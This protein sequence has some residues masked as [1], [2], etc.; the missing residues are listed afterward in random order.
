[1]DPLTF[2]LPPRS[3]VVFSADPSSSSF[4]HLSTHVS[5]SNAG[6]GV[7]PAPAPVSNFASRTFSS[8]TSA[9]PRLESL[10][11]GGLSRD[12]IA[13]YFNP[14][15]ANFHFGEGHPMKPP[16]LALTYHL[17]LG[18]GLHR[19]MEV[20][21][22]R[23]ATDEEI[24]TFHSE[25]YI[26]FLKRVN[27]DNAAD[28]AKFM[29]RFNLGVDDCPVFEGMYDFCQLYSGGSLE[30]ARK[31][32]AGTADIAIN[33]SGG[34]HHAKKFEASG[35]CYVNDIVLAILELM[36]YFPRV[37]YIDIDVH[38][39]D[40]VQEAFLACPRVMTVSFHKYDGAFFPG[41]GSIEE[42]GVKAGK[43]YSINVPLQE[44]IDDAQYLYIF[45]HTISLVM[46]TYQPS[47]VVLQ[48]GADSLASDRLGC[49][50]L[51]IRGHGE[52]VK[53]VKS[54]RIPMLV[55]GGGGYTIRNVARAWTYECSILTNTVVPDELPR[56]DYHEHFA[57]DYSLHP[58][59]VDPN[60]HDAN[61]RQSLDA[62]K[63][64]IAEYLRYIASAPSV[65]M[66]EV[67]PGIAAFMDEGKWKDEQDDKWL[68]RRFGGLASGSRNEWS[69]PENE[70]EFYEG[71]ADQGGDDS[72]ELNIG[73]D[74]S[75]PNHDNVDNLHVKAGADWAAKRAGSPERPLKRP[76]EGMGA[77]DGRMLKVVVTERQ[78]A[79]RSVVGAGQ[80]GY[81]VAD[82]AEVKFEPGLAKLGD[83]EP[84]CSNETEFK[85]EGDVR[86]IVGEVADAVSLQGV[87]SAGQLEHG[88]C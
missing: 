11:L 38:H 2:Q 33:Y 76:S 75:G 79:V 68:D 78:P 26:E 41:T 18:Y 9:A 17:V 13:Y 31:L 34:L 50:N 61:T 77:E 73:G 87:G 22:P 56:T 36:R 69:G 23:R 29:E 6:A 88:E 80:S 64:K 5:S 42:V 63:Q 37:L 8:S 72:E 81:P 67:P 53:F 45:K 55:V 27:P 4:S 65:Q 59:I 24:A 16:R 51:S 86:Y 52:C 74:D 14:E 43:Y 58:R 1:M 66:Q 60:L 82:G 71:E 84:E 12:R 35:F 62:V 15:V 19:K 3:S 39:G 25:E 46:D 49:F 54:Y 30:A 44:Y 20:Y 21:C 47:A 28:W 40:G 10:P 57:P 83:A 85:R 70:N 32:I 48:C 7:P